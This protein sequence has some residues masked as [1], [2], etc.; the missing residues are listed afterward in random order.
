MLST[1]PNLRDFA[2]PGAPRLS[3]PCYNVPPIPQP[4]PPVFSLPPT[5]LRNAPSTGGLNVYVPS[6]W[7][8]G[9]LPAPLAM[10]HGL[11]QATGLP[12]GSSGYGPPHRHYAAQCDYWARMAHSA[13]PAE[14]ISLEI[15]AV[16]E[17]RGK[18]RNTCTNNIGVSGH[19]TVGKFLL[20]WHHRVYAKG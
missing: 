6:A 14:T 15:S 9:P 16:Y 12:P 18:K 10:P 19:S 5:P 17:S 3:D 11:S 13:P 2:V 20:I 1:A 4:V 7:N 8:K